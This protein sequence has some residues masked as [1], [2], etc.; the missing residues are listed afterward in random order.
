[1]PSHSFA[2]WTSKNSS[3]FDRAAAKLWSWWGPAKPARPLRQLRPPR[4]RG[5]QA[6]HLLHAER[7]PGLV[8]L[9]A[10]QIANRQHNDVFA[11]RR[12]RSGCQLNRTRQKRRRVETF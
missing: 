4:Q 9:I 1:M 11:L 3:A 7:V 2:D 12:I 6:R 10:D 8:T 5:S